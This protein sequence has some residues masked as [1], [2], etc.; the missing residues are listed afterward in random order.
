MDDEDLKD[1][2]ENQEEYANL[3]FKA[4]GL[5][6]HDTEIESLFKELWD[7]TDMDK[8]KFDE[9]ARDS[10]PDDVLSG[11]KAMVEDLEDEAA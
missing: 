2:V 5:Q 3:Y 6:D 8:H 10:S 7:K 11:L 9:D 4:T 1:F